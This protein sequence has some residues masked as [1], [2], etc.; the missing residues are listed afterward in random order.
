MNCPVCRGHA[1]SNGRFQNRNRSVQRYLC[2]SPECGKSF[3]E[4]QPLGG[5]RIESDQAAH[6]VEM[7]CEGVGVRATARL[8]R[9]DTKTVL[10]VLSVA[11][12]QCARFLDERMRNLAV[13]DVEVDELYA[14]VGCLQA[15]TGLFDTEQGEINTRFW[16]SREKHQ[17]PSCPR[18][19]AYKLLG[20]QN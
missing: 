17:R 16:P 10:R 4:S 9:V 18:A 13:N 8:A 6:I 2:I 20:K 11:G 5:I 7:L 12:Q 14:F 15:S 1:K 19:D 3:S